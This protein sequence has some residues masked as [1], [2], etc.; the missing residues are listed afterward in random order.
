V[1]IVPDKKPT[2]PSSQ[3]V[4]EGLQENLWKLVEKLLTE[5]LHTLPYK[6]A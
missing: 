1:Q 6:L 2:E 4:D 3:A 5:K